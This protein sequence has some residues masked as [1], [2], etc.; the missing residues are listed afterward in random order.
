MFSPKHGSSHKGFLPS[1][2]RIPKVSAAL[3]AS[4][5]G[6]QLMSSVSAALEATSFAS[7]RRFPELCFPALLKSF[8]SNFA[9][10]WGVRRPRSYERCFPAL[11][12]RALLPSL[13]PSGGSAAPEATSVASQS[14]AFPVGCPPASKLRA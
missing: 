4:S 2:L 6:P 8:A 3:E 7:K 12:P 14:F 11:L 10:Q 5:F 1:L 9:S 13:L